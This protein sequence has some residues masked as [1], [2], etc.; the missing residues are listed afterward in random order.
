MRTKAPLW[1]LAARR[2]PGLAVALMAGLSAFPVPSVLPMAG[3]AGQGGAEVVTDAHS[4]TL[5]EMSRRTGGTQVFGEADSQQPLVFGCGQVFGPETTLESLAAAFGEANV[6]SADVHVGEG[7]YEPGAIIFGDT[8]NRVEVTWRDTLNSRSPAR[9]RVQ[10]AGSSWATPQGLRVG[11]DLHSVAEINGRPF[12]LTGFGWDYSGT[13]VSWEGG[14]LEASPG[15]RCRIFTRLAPA[16]EFGDDPEW[17]QAAN[18]VWG[19]SSYPSDHPA[20]QLLNPTVYEL[21][22]VFR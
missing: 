10:N 2:T 6:V 12:E 22:I 1:R 13:V 18:Q 5:E 4:G 16:E 19:S 3:A 21:L 11:L 14:Q 20:M 9:V 15:E 17:T 7:L 8:E